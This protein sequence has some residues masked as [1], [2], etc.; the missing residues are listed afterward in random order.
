MKF[1]SV[2]QANVPKG[3]DGKHKQIVEVLLRDLSQLG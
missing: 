2:L 3:R 1:E